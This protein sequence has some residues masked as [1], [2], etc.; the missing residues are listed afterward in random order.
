MKRIPHKI[1]FGGLALLSAGVTSIILLT[2][3]GGAQ[4]AWGSPVILG[5]AIGSA[6]LLGAFCVVETRVEEPIIPLNLFRIRTFSVA[7]LVSFVIGFTMF[8]AIVYLPAVP[9]GRRRLV[10]DQVG[11]PAAAAGRRDCSS[12]SS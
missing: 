3:W 6:A 9:P 11:A 10:A 12:P 8:G 1:D 5:M 2:T 7:T 4:Y